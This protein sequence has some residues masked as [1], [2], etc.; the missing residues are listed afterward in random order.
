MEGE[1]PDL[2]VGMRRGFEMIEAESV[3]EKPQIY[4]QRMWK[5][6]PNDN[7]DVAIAAGVAAATLSRCGPVSFAA[8]RAWKGQ[9]EKRI[10]NAYTLRLLGPDEAEVLAGHKVRGS[11]LHNVVDAVG[12]GLWKLGRR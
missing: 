8:P 5:G 12:I 7:V 6:D 3:I 9:R 4:R 2:D 11:K 1:I 10:D